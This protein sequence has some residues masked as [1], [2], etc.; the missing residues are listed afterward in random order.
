MA[1]I[2]PF[3]LYFC[4]LNYFTVRKY[5]LAI[6]I[7]LITSCVIYA[8][9][10]MLLEP[11]SNIT[12]GKLSNGLTYYF[13]E[14]KQFKGYVDYALVR[15]VG[16][17]SETESTRGMNEIITELSFGNTSNFRNYSSLD[18]F[19][20]LGINPNKNLKIDVG[21]NS[22]IISVSNVNVANRN[23]VEDS[24]LLILYNW[25]DRISFDSSAVVRAQSLI[26]NKSLSSNRSSAF[27]YNFSNKLINSSV[28]YFVQAGY[29]DYFRYSSSDLL[30]F[31][32]EN[33]TPGNSAIII[34]GDIDREKL[35]LKVEA[36]FQ[37]I[38]KSD[39]INEKIIPDV[40]RADDFIVLL[41]K[42]KDIELSQIDFYFTA[43]VLP[44]RYRLSAVP[45]VLDYLNFQMKELL[46]RRITFVS[47]QDNWKINSVDVSYERYLGLPTYNSLH[48]CIKCKSE[49]IKEI[50]NLCAR[51]LERIRRF[52]FNDNELT[53]MSNSF[54]NKVAEKGKNLKYMPN[55]IFVR[56]CAANFL[57]SYTLAPEELR[58]AYLSKA[59]NKISIYDI[60][61]YTRT[62]LKTTFNTISTCLLAEKSDSLSFT[63][64]DMRQILLESQADYTISE[65]MNRDSLQFKF[66]DTTS[67]FNVGRITEFS[68]T[69]SNI[70]YWVLPNGA[71][72]IYKKVNSYE[73]D[74]SFSAVSTKKGALPII[75]GVEGVENNI[76]TLVN[77]VKLD[78]YPFDLIQREKKDR[79]VI[80]SATLSKNT[81][82]INGKTSVEQLPYFCQMLN[83][84]FTDLSLD[85]DKCNSEIGN[86]S[87]NDLLSV[88]DFISKLYESPSDYNFIFV[89]NADKEYVKEQVLKY[90]ST[91]PANYYNSTSMELISHKEAISFK[92]SKLLYNYSSAP[93]TNYNYY[94]DG[95]I[96][97]TLDGIIIGEMIM[98][99]L[100]MNLSKLIMDDAISIKVERSLS[101]FPS[102]RML[103]KILFQT[104]DYDENFISNFNS[105][106]LDLAIKDIS[107][108]D[109]H[110]IENMLKEQFELNKLYSIDYWLELLKFRFLY[111]K[112]YVS[113][114]YNSLSKITSDQF[115]KEFKKYIHNSA[116]YSDIEVN[117]IKIKKNNE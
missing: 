102:D 57:E 114:Y 14:N 50:Y 112:D 60:N 16:L 84:Y 62:Y 92:Q 28:P 77:L 63:E 64:D 90:I 56:K 89:G 25:A 95:D 73:G 104:K 26:A 46:S 4:H 97:F 75:L 101:R 22:T 108:E 61:T 86:L 70:D 21:N 43:D 59:K 87:Y 49:D 39:V 115:N 99:Y 71:K 42:R 33:Y 82:V 68:D 79:D 29:D 45:Y 105:K 6:F 20:K 9:D 40:K 27:S 48:L 117:S 80:L 19:R 7:C 5:I 83:W 78:N 55:S 65:F 35:K 81:S 52:G 91:I 11:D 23:A 41:E 111:A 38:P 76:N 88:S 106:L 100:D 54:V 109:F 85:I 18:Y 69:L 32:Q 12:V 44:K 94:L 103:I 74:I 66:D 93:K 110:L 37:S 17:F 36:L 1:I 2:N 53:Q 72:V 31:Y 98:Q 8:Q 107:D 51:E 3:F 30:D 96:E 34:A 24:L 15:K 58:N 13:V 116:R 47:Y 10:A 67:L 113:N